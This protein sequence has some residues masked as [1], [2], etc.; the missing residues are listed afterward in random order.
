M[1]LVTASKLNPPYFHMVAQR[2]K[3]LSFWVRYTNRLLLSIAGVMAITIG[4]VYL[5]FLNQVSMRGYV[6]NKELQKNDVITSEKSQ[7][8]AQIARMETREY[9]SKKDYAK[10]MVQRESSQYFVRRDKFTAQK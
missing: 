6:L 7:L 4:M 1:V 3:Q 5:F 10:V 9:L 8:V 2:R